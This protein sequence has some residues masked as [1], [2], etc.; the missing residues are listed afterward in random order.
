MQHAALCQKRIQ[1][2]LEP[3]ARIGSQKRRVQHGFADQLLSGPADQFL[4]GFVD[5]QVTAVRV[6]DPHRQGQG[7]NNPLAELKAAEKLFFQA[8]GG[9]NVHAEHDQAVGIGRPCQRAACTR[10]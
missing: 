7:I 3:R 6:I 9:G 10:S 4:I 5:Q 8:H 2:F 1:L